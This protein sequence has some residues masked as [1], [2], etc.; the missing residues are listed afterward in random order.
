MII[1]DQQTAVI[2]K[3]INKVYTERLDENFL[4][5]IS[6]EIGKLLDIQYFAALLFPNRY[7]HDKLLIS[8][9]PSEFVDVYTHLSDLDF[10]TDTLIKTNSITVYREIR[11]REFPGK[12]EFLAETQKVRPV[13]DCCYIPLKINNSLAGIFAAARGGLKGKLLS[14]NDIQIF[15]FIC[16]FINEGFIRTLYSETEEN[17]ALL[18]SY[19]EVIVCGQKIKDV[20]SDLAGK[21]SYRTPMKG[22][23]VFSYQFS[24]QFRVFLSNRKNPGAGEFSLINGEREYHFILKNLKTPYYRN[25]IPEEPQYSISLVKD[26]ESV[27][28]EDIHDFSKIGT[29]YELTPREKEVSRYIFKGFSNRE[30]SL[31]LKISEGTVKQ[32]IWNI[33]N[34]T[35]VDSRTQLIFKLSS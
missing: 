11:D 33:F 14:D 15:N 9:N 19:G 7:T 23:S 35:G 18:N 17:T 4:M 21:D 6:P 28:R 5:E 32:H 20:F 3:I 22:R 16:G 2:R 25:Y 31:K 27:C 10:L 30:I 8:N 12:K 26:N 24:R 29:L 1:N 34:K 13:S